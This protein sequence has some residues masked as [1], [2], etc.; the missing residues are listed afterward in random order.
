MMTMGTDGATLSADPWWANLNLWKR[1]PSRYF[2][3]VRVHDIELGYP[4]R[5]PDEEAFDNIYQQVRLLGLRAK[6]REDQ[7]GFECGRVFTVYQ[8]YV[9]TQPGLCAADWITLTALHEQMDEQTVQL[10][11]LEA[12]TYEGRAA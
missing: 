7:H 3:P 8:H 4:P 6:R 11:I 9:R 2:G 12:M 5:R 1:G 10:A